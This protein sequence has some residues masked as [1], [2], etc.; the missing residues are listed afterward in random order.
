MASVLTRLLAALR[1]SAISGKGRETGIIEPQI[2]PARTR[3]GAAAPPDAPLDRTTRISGMRLKRLRQITA[4]YVDGAHETMVTVGDCAFLPQ[5]RFHDAAEAIVRTSGERASTLVATENA[6]RKTVMKRRLGELTDRERATLRAADLLC[7]LGEFERAAA[8]RI[9]LPIVWN[10]GRCHATA[11]GFESATRRNFLRAGLDA[12]L[13]EFSEPAP[14]A[15][16]ALRRAWRNALSLD[17]T[18]SEEEYR[19]L[20][21]CQFVDRGWLSPTT[22]DEEPATASTLSLGVF[23]GTSRPLL[24]DHSHGVITFAPAESAKRHG[25]IAQNLARLLT[26]AVVIDVDGRA[27]QTSA[28]RRQKEVGKIFAF[29]PALTD[30]SLHYNPIA[31]VAHDPDNA[32]NEARLLADLLTGRHGPDEEG[33]SYVAPAIYDVA[34]SDQPERRQISR[35]LARVACTERQLAEWTAALARSPQPELVRHARVLRD[36]DPKKR[37]ALAARLMRELSVWQSPPIASLVDR[38]DWTPA[39]LR[40]RATLYLCVSRDELDNYAVVL[41]VIV[42]QMLAALGRGAVASPGTTVTFFLD[43]VAR[44]GPMGTVARAV[45]TGP[46]CGVRPWMFFASAAEMRTTYPKADGMIAN[47][48]AHCYVEPDAETAHELSLRLGFAKSLFGTEEKAMVSED[49]LMGPNFADKIIALVRN[50]APARLV[51]A[52]EPKIA[53][54]SER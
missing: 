36:F 43:E 14:D 19:V 13:G 41:R 15:F 52:G 54:R 5:D 11:P 33:R 8:L 22:C 51:L 53:Q 38:S 39:D 30:H 10:E 27:F 42:G 47:C 49:D 40:H 35:V 20:E 50:Q 2:R 3:A 37:A 23:A 29:A 26:G 18:L 24:Y 46:A 7:E 48:A 32:W 12:L 28:R 25:Q 16:D 1:G 31:A 34:L 45:D 4:F 6:M 21:A 9:R 17:A 44:L